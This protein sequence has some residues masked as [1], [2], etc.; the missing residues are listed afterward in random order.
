MKIRRLALLLLLWG[1]SAAA[2][3]TFAADKDYTDTADAFA[4]RFPEAWKVER[5]TTEAGLTIT[6]LAADPKGP[7]AH[8]TIISVHSS[9]PIKAENLNDI[10]E[11]LNTIG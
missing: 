5:Q 2:P 11:T 6:S 7:S 1:F 3:T 10:A 9:E 4:L 8:V